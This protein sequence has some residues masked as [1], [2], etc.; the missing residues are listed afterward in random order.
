MQDDNKDTVVV[1]P[2]YVNYRGTLFLES[3]LT[4]CSDCI[5]IECSDASRTDEKLFLE[6]D[7]ADIIWIACQWSRSVGS[8][9]TEF[10]FKSCF[11]VHNFINLILSGFRL[12]LYC[13]SFGLEQ[14]LGMV[15][16]LNL[17]YHILFLP[18]LI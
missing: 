17:F 7:I 8:A 3:Q 10:F 4:F 15:F 6:F 12:E 16:T 14:M 9:V 18:S 2:D 5:K 13:L 11:D 1:C